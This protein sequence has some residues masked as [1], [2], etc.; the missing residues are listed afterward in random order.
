MVTPGYLAALASPEE[1]FEQILVR[2][3]DDVRTDQFADFAGGFRARVH[4]GLDA[5]DVA[6][7]TGR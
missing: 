2:T 5:A 1:G 6:L 7:C 4:R 3:R